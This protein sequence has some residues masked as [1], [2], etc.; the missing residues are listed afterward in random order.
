MN[1]L[2]GSS[3]SMRENGTF[4]REGQKVDAYCESGG[5]GDRRAS[6]YLSRR[7]RAR[8]LIVTNHI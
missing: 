6:L 2:A 3:S 1:Y 8:Q 7:K 4:P 5:G